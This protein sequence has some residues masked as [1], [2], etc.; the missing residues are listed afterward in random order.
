VGDVGKTDRYLCDGKP[1]PRWSS[2]PL[3]EQVMADHVLGRKRVGVG[4]IG[5]TLFGVLDF[6]G[7]AKQSDGTYILDP[8]KVEEAWANTR[9]VVAL[10]ERHGLNALVEVSRSVGGWHVWVLG[11]PVDPPTV[12]EMRRL[13]RAALRSL[14]LPD[15]GD[16][17]AGHPGLFPHPPGAKGCGRAPFLPW[18]GLLN[19]RTGAL[20]VDV[21]DGVPIER[22]ETALEDARLITRSEVLRATEELHA[23]EVE[24]REAAGATL[25]RP[26][27]TVATDPSALDL[28]VRDDEHAYPKVLK[29]AMKLRNYHP[30]E[31]GAQLVIAYAQNCGVIERH[32]L[33]KVQDLIDTAWDKPPLFVLTEFARE[34]RIGVGGEWPEIIPLDRYKVPPFP[35][36]ALPETLGQFVTAT[37]TAT[38]TPADLAGTLVLSGVSAAIGGTVKVLAKAGWEV[39]V[40][41]YSAVVLPSGDLKTPVFRAVME[42]IES[43]ER[44][45]ALRIEP[46]VRDGETRSA[47]MAKQLT[48]AQDRAAKGGAER[49]MAMNEALD[50]AREIA[51]NKPPVRP[52]FVVDDV[53]SEKVASLLAA[54]GG[55]LSILSSEGGIFGNLFGRYA[56]DKKP[57]FE[58][59]LKAYDAEIIRVDRES[60]AS[61]F[62]VNPALTMGLAVQPVV[63]DALMSNKEA[64]DRGLLGRFNFS[65]PMSL[66]GSRIADPPP[67]SETV[68]ANYLR[69]SMRLLERR[70]PRTDGHLDPVVL[71]LEPKALRTV[72][73]LQND[74]EPRLGQQGDLCLMRSWAGKLAGGVLRLAGQLHLAEAADRG[75]PEQPVIS[76]E[77]VLRA[78]SLGG[79]YLGHAQAAFDIMGATPATL[80][81]RVIL[82]WIA[83]KELRSF[84]VRDVYREKAAQFPTAEAPLPALKVLSER[85]Y[86]RQSVQAKA[87]TGRNP[88][89]KYEVNPSVVPGGEVTA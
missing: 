41:T 13:L 4:Q 40:N 33:K 27:P 75:E 19:G 88:S 5:S 56:G 21:A 16:E 9:R 34:E 55:R 86:I 37:A 52:R 32:G 28:E 43:F 82:G 70:V 72:I 79:Y 31:F 61:E 71:R 46:A 57:N 68:K 81:A 15:D 47:I 78:V 8:I 44:L 10:F 51:E 29:L 11:D 22:Q 6:D 3:T 35:V 14:G 1:S 25:A 50:L 60:R 49:L 66:I 80:E 2:D 30:K 89:P 45:E 65:V 18:S 63:L 76:N 59:I 62:I 53:T 39:P 17:G 42:P 20:F 48:K 24:Q 85:G 23:A 12:E 67:V 69:L 73:A 87:E 38:R 74:I 58:V 77:T 84:S 7:K 54:Q 83:A 36:L 26:I 64:N